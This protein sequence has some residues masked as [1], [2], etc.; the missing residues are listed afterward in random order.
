MTISTPPPD[1]SGGPQQQTE[2]GRSRGR[3]WIPLA[4]AVYALLEIWLLI[5]VGRAAGG[6]TVLLLLVA[7]L[8]LGGLAIRNAGRSAWRSLSEAVRAA[9]PPGQEGNE[10]GHRAGED[11]R[12]GKGKGGAGALLTGGLLLMVP[13]LISDVAGLL[14]LFPPTRSLLTRLGGRALERRVAAHP[15]EQGSLGDLF[16]QARDAE[17][18]IRIHRPDGKVIQGEVVDRG[19]GEDN[20]NPG[21]RH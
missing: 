15:Q 10:A 5:L 16:R 20:E 17:T 14:F 1:G 21:T 12:G 9:T 19:P 7:G 18:Q 13:G 3:R 4:A 2:Q 8:V 6:L 11:T